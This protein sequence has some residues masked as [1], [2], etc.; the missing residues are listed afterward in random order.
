[1]A[2]IDLE[3][4]TKQRSHS[5]D[6]WL[7]EDQTSSNVIQPIDPDLLSRLQIGIELEEARRRAYEL[8][9]QRLAEIKKQIDENLA[10]IKRQKEETEKIKPGI[11]G[12]DPVLISLVRRAM[13][14]LIAYDVCGV[15]PMTGPTGLIFAMKSK[16]EKDGKSE[17]VVKTSTYNE[18]EWRDT[19][20]GGQVR[21][22]NSAT[23]KIQAALRE[24]E[25]EAMRKQYQGTNT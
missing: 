4:L 21:T 25:R 6:W 17:P 24:Q 11:A 1:M 8:E 2:L 5:N 13:P 22:V 14:N 23:R 3:L 15:Q 10:E 16:Y 20:F 19:G 18:T 7:P 9:Q 12:F